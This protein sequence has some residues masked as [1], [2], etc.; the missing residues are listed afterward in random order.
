MRFLNRVFL[1]GA[2]TLVVSGCGD[3]AGKPGR[4]PDKIEVI[5]ADTLI[6]AG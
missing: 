5:P 3:L 1:Y 6:N 2:V 4:V